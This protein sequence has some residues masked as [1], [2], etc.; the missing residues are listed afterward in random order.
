MKRYITTYKNIALLALLGLASCKKN[1]TELNTN[2]NAIA[3]PTPQ[4]IFTK[5][6]YD[7]TANMLNLLLGTMQ[8]TTS[9]NDVSGFGS[10][11]IASQVNT[12]SAAFANAY[13][14]EINEL[15]E[16]IKAVSSDASQVNLLAEA[17]IWRV[18][19]FRR[20]KDIL[21]VYIHRLMMRKALFMPTC[22]PSSIRRLKAW[23]PLRQPLARQMVY[24]A[25]TLHNGKN[26]R[27]R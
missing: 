21:T 4:Y 22:L 6:E 11:Y 15:E 24:T 16:V 18:Y 12:T 20:L 23:T 13:P 3:T 9:F 14:N 10:K 2:P 17:R 19:C 8:Y 1:F 25:A 5:A 26:L 27:T 7:G